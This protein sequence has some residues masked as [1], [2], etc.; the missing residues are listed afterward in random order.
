M[1]LAE[2]ISALSKRSLTSDFFEGMLALHKK[3]NTPQLFSEWIVA[4]N[5]KVRKIP[6][7]APSSEVAEVYNNL[8]S[9][10]ASIVQQAIDSEGN[11]ENHP[12][13][14]IIGIAQKNL[15]DL[16]ENK[17]TKFSEIKLRFNKERATQVIQN[18]KTILSK[19]YFLKGKPD[20]LLALFALQRSTI[21]YLRLKDRIISNQQEI[22]RLLDQICASDIF[23][24][25][26]IGFY[27]GY[28]WRSDPHCGVA[29][30][31]Y[32]RKCFA[33]DAEL[34]LLLFYPRISI[35]KATTDALLEEMNSSHALLDLFKSRYPTEFQT[36]YDKTT[37]SKSLY[38]Y[39]VNTTKQ[40]RIFQNYCSLIFCN[41][42][43]IIG[44]KVIKRVF[45]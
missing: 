7:N 5:G 31:L 16:A 27:S 25:G 24:H 43:I 12:T 40:A 23:N 8:A 37:S 11:E 34:P 32:Y 18:P 35:S 15:F 26:A 9:L 28:K 36:K 20:K 14:N 42:G 19:K 13:T 41:D 44:D 29:V 4:D 38:H 6:P 21:K 3:F 22:S 33:R 2:D 17:N 30:N 45:S 39:W 10:I 1:D